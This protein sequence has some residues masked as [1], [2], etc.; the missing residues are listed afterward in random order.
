MS[1]L[2]KFN[3]GYSPNRDA[4]AN[5]FIGP[6]GTVSSDTTPPARF[7]GSPSGSIPAGT[8]Q[9]TMSLATNEN[10]TCK[11]ATNAGTAYSSMTNTFSTTGGTNHS[12]NITGLQ[13]GQSYNR[14]I[15]CIDSSGNANTDDFTISWSV[16]NPPAL[17]GDLNSDG[18][19]DIF[20]YN[21][22]LQNFGAINCGN[23]ADLN[24]DCKVNI[25][26]YNILLE[27]FGVNN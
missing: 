8:T 23:V 1:I 17:T 5:P 11:F 6:I 3:I 21:I 16:A 26:D 12:V 24:G 7:N 9:T 14:Y 2:G 25:F 10:A 19:V 13:N 20:D 4:Q 22:F 18:V 27:N 15:R